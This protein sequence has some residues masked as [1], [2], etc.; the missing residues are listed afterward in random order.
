MKNVEHENIV[1]LFDMIEN[2]REKKIYLVM[3]Y[4]NGGTLLKKIKTRY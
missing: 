2:I 4:I 1:K 3:Q